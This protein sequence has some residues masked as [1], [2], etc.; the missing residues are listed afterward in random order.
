MT[1]RHS[2]F[3]VA[4]TVG[5]GAILKRTGRALYESDCLGWSAELAYYWFLALF[6][7]LLFVVALTSYIPAQTLI[8]VIVGPLQHVAPVG[9]IEI[10]RQQ[11]IQITMAPH[12]GVLTFSLLGTLWSSSA[13]MTALIS[14]LNQVYQ[15]QD[16]RPWWRVQLLAIALTWRWRRSCSS[17]SDC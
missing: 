17:P 9:V 2:L 16:R 13:G 3:A 7:A 14:T 5:W 15:V 12:R 10:V 6:P 11:L 4:G 8:D 1:G